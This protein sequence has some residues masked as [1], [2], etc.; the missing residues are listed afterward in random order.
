VGDPLKNPAHR[1]IVWRSRSKYTIPYLARLTSESDSSLKSRLQYFRAFDFVPTSYDKSMALLG[2][3][4]KKLPDHVPVSKLALYHL[5]KDFIQESYWGKIALVK[6]LNETYGT[7]DYIEL[8]ARYEP[9]FENERLYRLAIDRPDT[10]IGRDAGRQ[11]LRQAPNSY[12]WY[13]LE[14]SNDEKQLALLASIKAV[15]SQNS[16]TVLASVA[17]GPSFAL[18]IRQR[19]ARY[20]GG[21][22]EGEDFV[23]KLLKENRLHGEI[24]AAALDGIS[25]AY[26]QEIRDEADKYLDFGGGGSKIFE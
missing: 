20:L 17:A 21:S 7:Q 12:I 18:P 14:H 16:L 6:L 1:D 15:G 2:I 11:L 13:K 5:G 8:T 4:Q 10:D 26:R 9:A 19:A 22:W 24:K 25:Q 3:T 23:L